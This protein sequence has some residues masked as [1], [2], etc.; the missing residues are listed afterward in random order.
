MDFLNSSLI[1]RLERS[2]DAASLRQNV[3]THNI[4]NVDTPGFKRST[5]RFEEFLQEELNRSSSSLAG[6]R[7]HE[8][9]FSFGS[10]IAGNSGPV[11][12][13]DHLSVMN[14]N[15][16]NVDIDAEMSMLAK[17]QLNY[18]MLVQQISH[19]LRSI[20]TSIGGR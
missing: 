5:V 13:T 15:K 4:A 10:T 20:R 12:Q 6:R 1:N 16:N 17:N 9:H 14:N 18:N 3:I 11:I 8:K 2:L 19:E 7:T